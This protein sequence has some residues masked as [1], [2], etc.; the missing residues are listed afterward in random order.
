MHITFLTPNLPPMVCGLADHARLLG[1]ALARRGYEVS[2][3]ARRGDA[4]A[5][6]GARWI[7][8][9]AIWNGTPRGLVR[10]LGQVRPDWLWVQ[11]SGYGYSRFGAPWKLSRALKAVRRRYRESRLAVCVHETYCQPGQ[12]GRK[13]FL[14]SPWQRFTVGQILKLGD[15]VLP[16]IPR[17]LDQCLHEYRLPPA[18]LQLLPVAATIAAARLEGEQRNRLRRELGLTPSDRVAVTFG[19]WNSQRMA[20]EQFGPVVHR[21]ITEGSLSSVVAVGGETS[22]P[23]AWVGEFLSKP[24]WAGRLR[25]LGNQV[26]ERVAEIIAVADVGLVPTPWPVWEKSTAA[27]AFEQ[28]GLTLWILDNESNGY[29]IRPP[30]ETPPSWDS[31]AATV[32]VRLAEYS[33]RRVP[34]GTQLSVPLSRSTQQQ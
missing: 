33:E 11:L 27:R 23:P 25:V 1:T 30:N 32:A 19:R 29:R 16:T 34:D 4:C 6:N 13:G 26:P 8:P 28:A 2:I 10:L 18:R 15:L 31:L 14:L 5:Q 12:L 9:T 17:Y 3:V 24:P 7:G 21:A 20:L 22:T